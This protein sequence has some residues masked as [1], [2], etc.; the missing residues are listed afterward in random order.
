M[1]FHVRTMR[2]AM[3]AMA[4]HGHTFLLQCVLF[5]PLTFHV[6]SS[7]FVWENSH[8]HGFPWHPLPPAWCKHE[9]ACSCG[10]FKPSMGVNGGKFTEIDAFQGL[11]FS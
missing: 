11:P 7:D 8:R 3:N 4:I 10:E 5:Y 2:A 9:G 6:S 1:V